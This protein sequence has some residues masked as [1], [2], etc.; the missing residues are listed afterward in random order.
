MQRISRQELQVIAPIRIALYRF[1]P[2]LH[3]IVER[4]VLPRYLPVSSHRSVPLTADFQLPMFL[5]LVY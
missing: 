4:A 5:S 3:A 2:L 1:V